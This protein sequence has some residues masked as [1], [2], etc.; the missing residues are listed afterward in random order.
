MA[1]EQE[2][3][4]D[5]VINELKSIHGIENLLKFDETN[6]REKLENNSSLIMYFTELYYRE[7]NDL[8]AIL[9]MKGKLVGDLFIKIKN[10]QGESLKINEFEK[11]YLPADIK[12][13]KLLSIIRKQQWRVDFYDSVRRALEK[14]GWSMQTYIKSMSQGL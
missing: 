2:K 1:E 13:V 6:I 7:K 3:T 4:Y 9:D 5:E 14:M 8:D 11:F 10:S 12:Y